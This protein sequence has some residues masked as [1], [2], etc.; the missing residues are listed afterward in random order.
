VRDIHRAVFDHDQHTVTLTVA[1]AG[2]I[3]AAGLEVLQ[4]SIAQRIR[5]TARIELMRRN[6]GS[7]SA[8]ALRLVSAVG[9]FA[10]SLAL[11]GLI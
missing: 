9:L 5:A 11:L 1:D 10:A 3:V 6:I 8:M 2:T 4:P 7:A